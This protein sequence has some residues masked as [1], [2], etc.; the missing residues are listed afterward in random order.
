[1]TGY[2]W[3]EW[4]S[5]RVREGDFFL[6]KQSFLSIPPEKKEE[7]HWRSSQSC[8]PP[9]RCSTNRG[10]RNEREEEEEERGGGLPFPF[11][12][13]LP[14]PIPRKKLAAALNKEDKGSGRS[15]VVGGKGDGTA[16]SG[17]RYR[18]STVVGTNL[19]FWMETLQKHKDSSMCEISCYVEEETV[20]KALT[21]RARKNFALPQ[22]I[23]MSMRPFCYK[24]NFCKLML[25]YATSRRIP[26]PD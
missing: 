22:G 2:G 20:E 15:R 24:K 14:S 11:L 8:P 4:L 6:D 7:R 18:E 26:A 17:K 21:E 1:M 16:G 25:W 5:G 10:K 23:S 3:H 19:S 13:R 12:F 9:L